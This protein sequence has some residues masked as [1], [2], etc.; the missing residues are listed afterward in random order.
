VCIFNAADV[1]RIDRLDAPRTATTRLCV[2]DDGRCIAMGDARGDVR[3][4]DPASGEE[5]GM[6]HGHTG[7]VASVA[8]APDGRHLASASDDGSCRLWDLFTGASEVI[9]RRDDLMRDAAF[10]PHE[11]WLACGGNA[12]PVRIWN[13]QTRTLVRELDRPPGCCSLRFDGA[14]E[15]LLAGGNDGSAWLWDLRTF[16]GRQLQAPGNGNAYA[17]FSNDGRLIAL[18]SAKDRL[19]ILDAATLQELHLCTGHEGEIHA[20]P[21][22][23]P[24]DQRVFTTG[25]DKTLRIWDAARGRLMCT[26][27]GHREWIPGL[28]IDPGGRWLATSD[29]L[30]N[31][32]LWSTAPLADQIEARRQARADKAAA[33]AFLDLRFAQGLDAAAARAKAA[34]AAELSPGARRYAERMAGI[35][36]GDADDLAVRSFD[37]TAPGDAAPAARELA[38]RWANAAFA[39]APQSPLVLRARGAVSYRAGDFTAAGTALMEARARNRARGEGRLPES[40]SALHLEALC[41]L[42]LG[43]RA[44]AERMLAAMADFAA[45][46]AE[47]ALPGLRAEVARLRQ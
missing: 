22:F 23:S 1:G 2:S 7:I 10:H 31:G 5:L 24:D 37:L 30:G 18:V 42:Q 44:D 35:R 38:A 16:A 19:R 21:V 32:R 46:S 40:L 29:N 36:S 14:G 9:E 43:R 39:L 26:L 12:S 3:L 8:G 25:T 13:L 34:D 41:L 28:G 11:P 45:D 17:S 4:V 47:P 20:V 27:G 15:R 33:E 6:L